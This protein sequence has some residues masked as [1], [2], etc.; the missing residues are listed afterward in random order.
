MHNIIYILLILSTISGVGCVSAQYQLVLNHPDIGQKLPVGSKNDKLMEIVGPATK[1]PKFVLNVEGV[2]F[3]VCV[4]HENEIS[5]IRTDD[6]NFVTPDG[7]RIGTTYSDLFRVTNGKIKKRIGWAYYVDLK[8][9]WKAAFVNEETNAGRK[10]LENSQ[11]SFLFKKSQLSESTSVVL[12]N[13]LSP[14]S[15][16][17]N[18]LV[19]KRIDTDKDKYIDAITFK[20]KYHGRYSTGIFLERLP[21]NFRKTNYDDLKLNIKLS[22]YIGDQLLLIQEPIKPLLHFVGKSEQG[23]WFS[24]FEAPDDLPV[25]DSLNCKLEVTI[26]DKKFVTIHGPIRFY[27]QKISEK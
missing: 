22:F 18:A 16:L 27:I 2:D 13:I 12:R 17:Y 11:V 20:I 21:A 23:V 25:D 4:N 24:T 3:S 1:K 8:S 6:I 15:D 10:L 7:V 14:P 5:Y 19:D 26:F 9:G